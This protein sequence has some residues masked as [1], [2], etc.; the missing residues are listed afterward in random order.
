M[1]CFCPAAADTIRLEHNYA[2]APAGRDAADAVSRLNVR[3]LVDT[4]GYLCVH[5][6]YIHLCS[7]IRNITDLKIH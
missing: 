7:N 1:C 2:A 6:A 5:A 3:Q 4:L